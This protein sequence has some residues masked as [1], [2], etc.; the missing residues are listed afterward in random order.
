MSQDRA[1]P[2]SR[3]FGRRPDAIVTSPAAILQPLAA[4]PSG[5]RPSPARTGQPAARRRAPAA[6]AA[7]LS[8]GQRRLLLGVVAALHALALWAI[9]QVPAVRQAVRES[10]PLFV[11]ILAPEA[12]PAPPKPPPP[13]RP[14]VT[15][16]RTPPLIASTAA[17]PSPAATFVV[18]PPPVEPAPAAPAPAPVVETPPQPAPPKVIP[19]SGVQY[20]TPPPLDYPRASRRLGETGRV[21]VR[22]YIDED[23]L[24]RNVQVNQSSGHARLDEAAVAAVHKARFKPYTENGRPTAGWA[25]IPLA[26]NLER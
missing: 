18:E 19:S 11:D 22:V 9:L 3:A 16:P 10:V 4:P 17:A 12:P 26:F 13:Q 15:P 7:E 14:T 25:F 24:P 1:A 6:P 21:L 2:T 20:L 5:P 8:A 23:G